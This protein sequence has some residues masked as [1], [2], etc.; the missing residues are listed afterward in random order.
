MMARIRALKDIPDEEP[1]DMQILHGLICGLAIT[2]VFSAFALYGF[3]HAFLV[4][5]ER[6]KV[7][8]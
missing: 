7:L 2:F 5:L 8:L 3:I 6:V 1:S 4:F